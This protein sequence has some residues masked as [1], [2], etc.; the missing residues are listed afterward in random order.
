[1]CRLIKPCQPLRTDLK[2]I[3]ILVNT[4]QL[5]VLLFSLEIYL[6]QHLLPLFGINYE[7]FVSVPFVR[8][9]HRSALFY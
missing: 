9:K 1:M 4:N 7:H 2:V 8:Q 6:Q 5:I 3:C